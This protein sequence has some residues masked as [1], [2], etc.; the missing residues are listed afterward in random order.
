MKWTEQSKSKGMFTLM[1]LFVLYD[2]N[3]TAEEK[4]LL[5]RIIGY[6]K[7]K[8]GYIHF[9]QSYYSFF[10]GKRTNNV[11]KLIKSLIEKGYIKETHTHM[12]KFYLLLND[13]KLDEATKQFEQKLYEFNKYEEE[14]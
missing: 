2:N 12:N 9:N 4:L 1:P 5:S 6:K 14:V 11:S 3:L 7:Q 13:Q 10:S 8:S